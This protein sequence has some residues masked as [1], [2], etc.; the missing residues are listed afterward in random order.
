MYVCQ[1]ID[2]TVFNVY[3]VIVHVAY[4]VRVYRNCTCTCTCTLCVLFECECYLLM[5][6]RRELQYAHVYE[7]LNIFNSFSAS[8]PLSLYLSPFS[9]YLSSQTW[10]SS[11]NREPSW[12]CC[13][14]T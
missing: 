9:Q 13:F 11:R 3:C 7:V 14:Y 4:H 5:Y 10:Q 12:D 8:L 1:V 2:P 6:T